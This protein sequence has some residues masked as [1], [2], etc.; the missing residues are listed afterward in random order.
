ML[1]AVRSASSFTPMVTG[2]SLALGDTGLISVR[3]ESSSRS[4]LSLGCGLISVRVG[5]VQ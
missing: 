4:V 3:V 5:C 2:S 1:Q